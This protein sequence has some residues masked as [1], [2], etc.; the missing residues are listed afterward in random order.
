MKILTNKNKKS[1]LY[2]YLV[3]GLI[4]IFVIA[5][6]V[7]VF[8]TLFGKEAG[9]VSDQIENLGDTDS[10]GVTDMFDNTCCDT[11]AG[12][13]VDKKGCSVESNDERIDCKTA[14]EDKKEE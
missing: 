2:R 9:H 8:N 14:R 10:D 13:E 1:Q 7:V 4:A 11:P 6:V 5:V 12:E 3:G